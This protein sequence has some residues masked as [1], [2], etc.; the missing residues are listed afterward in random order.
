MKQGIQSILSFFLIFLPLFCSTSCV[1]SEDFADTRSGTFEALWTML[2]EHY[3]FFDYKHAEYGLDWAEVHER[4]ARQVDEKMS[5]DA[6]FQVLSNVICELRDGHCNLV[7]GRDVAGYAQWYE[8]YPMNFSDSL[9]HKYVGNRDDYHTTCGMKYRVME[10]NVGYVRC[11]SF[12]VGMGDGNLHYI[13]DYLGTCDGLIVDVRSNSGGMLTSAMTLAGA[14]VNEPTVAGYIR[15]KTGPGHAD[16]SEPEPMTLTP[17]SGFRWQKP[18]VVLANRRTYSAANAFVMFMK[19]AG[20]TIVGDRTGGG[21]GMPFSSELPGG[22]SV[23][24]SA[25]PMTDVD[26][27]DTEFGI[28]PDHHVNISA[29]DYQRSVDTILEYALALLKRNN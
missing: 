24:F 20:A 14:F 13:F 10:G 17:A 28:V 2:D 5:D 22:W 25:C 18:V 29:E 26:G 6:L 16:F 3:C 7:S 21:S 27:R 12:D 1:T 19:A 4:Y 15:H 11:P 23:R 8:A 9:Q